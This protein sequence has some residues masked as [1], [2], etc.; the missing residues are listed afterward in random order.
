MIATP[1][2]PGHE[3][4]RI[5]AIAAAIGDVLGPIGD[6]TAP[7]PMGEGQLVVSTD[8]S[9]ENVHFRRP[10]LTAEEIGWRA[11]ASAVS[12]LAAAGAVPAGV[13]VAMIVPPEGTEHQIVDVMKGAAALMRTT[14]GIVLGGDLSSGPAWILTVTVI[15]HARHPLTRAGARVGDGVWVTGLLG[16]SRAAVESWRH[17]IEPAAAARLAFARPQPR[18]AAGRWLAAHGATAMIDLSDGLGGDAG[19]LA[20]A[21]DLGLA[22]TLESLPVHPAVLAVAPLLDQSPSVFAG[23]GGEDYELLLTLPPGWN[24]AADCEAETATRITRIGEV[25]AAPGLHVTLHGKATTL[26]GY[27]HRI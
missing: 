3:F 7:V 2:G 22:I 1:M 8:A 19:H 26:P 10:W 25:V 14:G 18:I 9:V 27:T 6:D 20:A 13:T 23:L 17:G 24:G 12:D 15:G 11:T 5:R 16:A 21:S 4:D